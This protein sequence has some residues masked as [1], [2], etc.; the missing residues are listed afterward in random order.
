[1]MKISEGCYV[2]VWYKKNIKKL[3]IPSIGARNM[4][5]CWRQKETQKKVNRIVYI[6]IT[7]KLK[8]KMCNNDNMSL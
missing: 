2:Y 8:S 7:S 5:F 1:M 6:N 3:N 4:S